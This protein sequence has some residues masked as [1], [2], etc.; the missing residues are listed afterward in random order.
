MGKLSRRAHPAASGQQLSYMRLP[1]ASAYADGLRPQLVALLFSPIA[2]EL[3]ETMNA[4]TWVR[5]GKHRLALGNISGAMMIYAT[6][7]PFLHAMDLR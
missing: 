4:I 5:Q 7:G 3:P 6:V 2:T 1:R